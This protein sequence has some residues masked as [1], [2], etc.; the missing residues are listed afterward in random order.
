MAGSAGALVVVGVDPGLA[1]FGACAVELPGH[2][3]VGADVFRSA[4]SVK[5]R[6]VAASDDRYRRARD[7]ASWFEASLDRW[8][9]TAIAAESMSFPRSGIAIASMALAWGVVAAVANR[10]TLPLVQVTPQEWKRWISGRKGV[11]DTALYPLLEERGGGEVAATLL[12]AGVPRGQHVH[13]FDALGVALW[14]EDA[15]IVRAALAG[16]RGTP[17]CGWTD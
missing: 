5:K 8:Q 13:A 2:R 7:L 16:A 3:V 6:A 12:D 4:P 1:S 14:S 11:P 15:E 9:P 17:A 10:R